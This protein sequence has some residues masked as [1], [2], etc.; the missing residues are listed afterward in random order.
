MY[1]QS[2]QV[3]Y[4]DLK[5]SEEKH[6]KKEKT[7]EFEKAKTGA[8]LPERV[9]RNNLKGKRKLFWRSTNLFVFLFVVVVCHHKKKKQKTKKIS[10]RAR[11][12]VKCGKTYYKT[13]W[14]LKLSMLKKYF[15]LKR[16]EYLRGRRKKIFCFGHVQVC[17]SSSFCLAGSAAIL[18]LEW[19][20]FCA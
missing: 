20:V 9:L 5:K 2:K 6:F 19:T 3:K 7:N 17:C 16:A 8:S 1:K 18:F 15:T 10:S 14:L 11:F 4:K 12:I 13:F